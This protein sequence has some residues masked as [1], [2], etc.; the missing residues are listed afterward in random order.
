MDEL[1]QM[2]LDL[3]GFVGTGSLGGV[4]GGVIHYNSTEKIAD[5]ARLSRLEKLMGRGKNDYKTK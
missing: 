1:Y 3:V 4:I 2:V 5:Q